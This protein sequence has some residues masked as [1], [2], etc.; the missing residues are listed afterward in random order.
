MSHQPPFELSRNTFGRLVLTTVSGDVHEGVTP[1]R[2]FPIAAP[3]E[4]IALVGPDGHEVAWVDRLHDLSDTSRALVEQE[5]ATREFF[6]E[7]R[8]L[9]SVST[10]STPSTWQVETDRGPTT[11]L[12]K[13]EEDIRRLGAQSVMILDGHGVQFVIRDLASLDKTSRRMLDRFLT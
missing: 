2:A 11:L 12:L 5:L 7:I 1:V 10:Y 13:G 4:G 9:V 3:D 6:P 8:R